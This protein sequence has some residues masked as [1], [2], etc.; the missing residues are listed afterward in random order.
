MG[1]W[2]YRCLLRLY[3]RALRAAFGDEMLAFFRSRR[4]AAAARGA[5]GVVSFWTRTLADLAASL[6]R[7]WRPRVESALEPSTIARCLARDGLEAWTSIRRRP[8]SS[9]SIAGL[10]ALAIGAA[11]AVFSVVNAVLL[12]PLPFGDPAR[13][14][15]VWETRSERQLDR[16]VVSGHEFPLWMER[17]RVFERMAAVTYGGVTLTGSGEPLSLSGV[18][19]TSGFGDVMGVQPFIGRGFGPDDDVPGR[20]QVA[21]VS[22][23]LWRDRFGSDAGLVGRQIRLNDRACTVI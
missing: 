3:P 2:I 21:L 18:R 5:I 8:A 20:G 19:V 12:R 23:R 17:N 15:T 22:H 14:V 6:W 11:T 7:E 9:L 4:S 1:D 10:L 16:N 13:I